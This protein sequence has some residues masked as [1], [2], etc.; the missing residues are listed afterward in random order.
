MFEA[1]ALSSTMRTLGPVVS[2]PLG[3]ALVDDCME[4]CLIARPPRDRRRDV[5][6][7][8]TGRPDRAPPGCEA[9]G[10]D[11]PFMPPPRPLSS[12]ASACPGGARRRAPG[13]ARTGP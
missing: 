1:S 7:G 2:P 10:V 12:T 5:L 6:R 9:G 3:A 13:R 8:P 4:P 11:A